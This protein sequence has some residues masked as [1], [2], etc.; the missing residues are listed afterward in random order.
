MVA[1]FQDKILMENPHQNLM[2]QTRDATLLF[3][4]VTALAMWSP[5]CSR[6]KL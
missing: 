4:H 6:K 3:S 5:F 1:A 2:Q